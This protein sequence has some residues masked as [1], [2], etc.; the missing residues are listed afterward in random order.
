[1][2]IWDF[3][4]LFAVV[5]ILLLGL[6]FSLWLFYT[7]NRGL[8]FK[9]SQEWA[10]F[11]QCHYCGYVYMDHFKRNPCRCPQCLSYHDQ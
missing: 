6:V 3:G 5:L 11:R 2:F 7:L 4:A 9:E 8:D 1:M 10:D